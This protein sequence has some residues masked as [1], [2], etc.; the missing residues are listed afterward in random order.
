MSHDSAELEA[1]RAYTPVA[2]PRVK[3]LA[4]QLLDVAVRAV[5]DG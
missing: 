3:E 1:A 2:W 4:S 5:A